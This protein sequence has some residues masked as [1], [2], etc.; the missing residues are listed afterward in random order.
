MSAPTNL[1][2]AVRHWGNTTT[3]DANWKEMAANKIADLEQQ[4]LALKARLDDNATNELEKRKAIIESQHEKGNISESAKVELQSRST[5][6]FETI[7]A[8]L[9][10]PSRINLKDLKAAE[11]KFGRLD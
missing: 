7:K 5:E 6:A 10:K 11:E 3:G 1:L 8:E 9:N 2:D 4:V